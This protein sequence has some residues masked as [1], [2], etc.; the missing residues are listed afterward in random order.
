MSA[1]CGANV[2]QFFCLLREVRIQRTERLACVEAGVIRDRRAPIVPSAEQPKGRCG[3]YR[4]AH[5]EAK[6]KARRQLP[7]G[8]SGEAPR[9]AVK[10]L[11]PRNRSAET[12]ERSLLKQCVERG[13]EWR[14][15]LPQLV[16]TLAQPLVSRETRQ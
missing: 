7:K 16:V 2:A 10:R 15:R 14:V 5:G 9:R 6:D 4:G 12:A 13:G 1:F 8:D 11:A 3:P